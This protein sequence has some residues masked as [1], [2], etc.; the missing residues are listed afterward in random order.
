M[1]LK[2]CLGPMRPTQRRL[3]WGAGFFC[4]SISWECRF[5]ECGHLITIKTHAKPFCQVTG[6]DDRPAPRRMV[7]G[8]QT[9]LR[10][11][12]SQARNL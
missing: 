11:L 12:S 1:G 4:M 6:K 9:F 3:F 7:A 8:N 5:A 10:L 2:R